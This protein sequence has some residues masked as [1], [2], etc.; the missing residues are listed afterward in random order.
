MV[1]A[2]QAQMNAANFVVQASENIYFTT[3]LSGIKGNNATVSKTVELHQ[4]VLKDHVFA[5]PLKKRW[6][7]TISYSDPKLQAKLDSISHQKVGGILGALHKETS[8]KGA[9][10]KG[11]NNGGRNRGRK[12]K[13]GNNP[14]DRKGNKKK[15]KC[16]LCGGRHPTHKCRATPAQKKNYRLLMLSIPNSKKP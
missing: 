15:Q 1:T 10:P 12:R 3:K 7:K 6:T 14:H 11:G 16:K 8:T 5:F 13:R 9:A 4:G 2:L